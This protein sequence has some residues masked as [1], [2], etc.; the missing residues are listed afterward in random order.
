[1]TGPFAPFDEA[2]AWLLALALSSVRW[3]VVSLFL[4]MLK[5]SVIKRTTYLGVV[6]AIA[7]PN[8]PVVVA[9]LPDRWPIAFWLPVIA[10]EAFIGVVVGVAAGAVFWAVQSAGTIIDQ[11]T[12]STQS[13]VLDPMNDQGGGPSGEFLTQTFT[14]LMLSSGAFLV[15]LGGI[16]DTYALWPVLSAWPSLS[17][18]FVSVLSEEFDRQFALGGA[19]ALPFLIVLLVVEVAVGFAGKAMPSLDGH[20]FAQGLKQLA[21]QFLMLLL[22]AA[23]FS[24]LIEYL[25]AFPVLDV[26]RRI[27]GG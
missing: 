10:K 16:Y 26:V 4:P 24:R 27:L 7:A 5:P 23:M 19:L 1:M 13:S 18:R 20:T 9:G 11:Q 25:A 2:L 14:T 3:L 22:L 17:E 12:G 8:V 21:A 15:L 6:F